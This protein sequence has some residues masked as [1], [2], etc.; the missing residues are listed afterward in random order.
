MQTGEN[1]QGLRK[2]IDLTR[3]IS[4][5]ILLL[6]FYFSCYQVFKQ[7]GLRSDITD[8][9]LQNIFRTGL[10]SSFNKPKL[11]ALIFLAISLIGARGRKNEK[12]QFKS[13]VIYIVT[14]LIFYFISYFIFYLNINSIQVAIAY[15]VATV[16]GFVFILT[17]GTLLS[18]IIHKKLS[19]NIFNSLN[20]TFP[21]E[22]RLLKNEYSINLPAQYNLKGRF[23]KS[24]IKSASSPRTG[25]ILGS[26]CCW[27]VIFFFPTALF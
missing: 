14:G 17:G 21:Q 25:G 2:I 18:R 20:E 9:I 6:H 5:G 24:W 16:T 12:I 23:R 1:E 10:F 22:E 3:M 4:I 27:K 13:S 8:R 19:N 11:I 26:N 15:M 7:W